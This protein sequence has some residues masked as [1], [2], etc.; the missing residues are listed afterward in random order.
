L[1]NYNKIKNFKRERYDYDIMTRDLTSKNGRRSTI[2]NHRLGLF[3]LSV[4]ERWLGSQSLVENP[5]LGRW[6]IMLKT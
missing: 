5:D 6:K 3:S 2:L 1:I 4:F